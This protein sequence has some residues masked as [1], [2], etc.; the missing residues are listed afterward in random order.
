M[1]T[2]LSRLEQIGIIPVIKID[3]AARAV[4]LAK[5][6]AAGGIPCA[7]ITFRTAQGAR[8]I[9]RINEEVPETLLGAGTVLSVEQ[10][11]K[12]IAA[13]AQFIVSPGFNPK[14]VAHCLEKGI[15]VVPG[16][17]TPSDI[18]RALEFGLEAVK[19]FPAEQAGGLD[20]IKAIVAPYT[21]LRFLPTGGVNQDNIGAYTRF[22]KVLACGGS[23]MAGSDLINTGGFDKITAL[24]KE[25]VRRMLGFS[26]T[27]IGINTR[28][29]AETR[30]AANRFETL[31]NFGSRETS[32]SMFAGES[33]EIMKGPGMGT[34]GHIA[35]AVNSVGK[36]RYH[37]ERQGVAFNE[38][39]VK[40][41]DS[42]RL[43]LIYIKDETAGFAIH[44]VQKK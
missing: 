8:A 35:I 2:I 15:P 39:S 12:A 38:E 5:A 22:E 23:W 11:D 27:H 21:S 25:A 42:G 34:H 40:Y 1:H 3:D 30:N 37:L 31:F 33:I 36:A 7:E 26:M 24:C 6:L 9:T 29:E 19:F 10:V 28:D 4:P 41:A 13:G 32:A 44:L 18:E 17:A 16:C 43:N 20:Y 14:V